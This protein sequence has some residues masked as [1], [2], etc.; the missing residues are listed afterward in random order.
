VSLFSTFFVNKRMCP[1]PPP[2]RRK[3]EQNVLFSFSPLGRGK[4]THFLLWLPLELT[5][6]KPLDPSA[7]YKI[8]GKLEDGHRDP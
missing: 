4:R 6:A 7:L 3:T 5:V 8:S 1:P 2:P